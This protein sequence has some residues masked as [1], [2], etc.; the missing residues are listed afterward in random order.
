MGEGHPKGRGRDMETVTETLTTRNERKFHW[1]SVCPLQLGAGA[2]EAKIWVWRD[3]G[4]AVRG[5]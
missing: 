1:R 4:G 5:P 2:Q 3:L